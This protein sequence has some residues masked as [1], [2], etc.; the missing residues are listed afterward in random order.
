MFVLTNKNGRF[1][2][3]TCLINQYIMVDLII[4]TIHILEGLDGVN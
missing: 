3:K 1:D 4:L 2:Q